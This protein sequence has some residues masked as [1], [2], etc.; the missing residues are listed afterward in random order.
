MTETT[1]AT[2]RQLLA[3]RYE[4][5]RLRLSRRLGS[6]DLASE[7]LHETYLHLDRND[8]LGP[9]HSPG[10]YVL[11]TA[12]NIAMSR[13]RTE[14]RYLKAG[15]IEAELDIADDAPGPAREAEGRLRLEELRR[16]IEDLPWRQRAIL[17]AARLEGTPHRDIAERFGISTRMV[18]LELKAALKFCEERLEK[19]AGETSV[20]TPPERLK[21]GTPD[22]QGAPRVRLKR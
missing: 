22:F 21:D 15:E 7:T 6:E 3:D 1:W 17:I 10:A 5:F 9:V 2:L 16:V 20:H 13:Y 11:K 12:F 8:P 14:G 18:Q 19:N 4:E